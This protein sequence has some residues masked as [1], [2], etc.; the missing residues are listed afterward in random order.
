MGTPHIPLAPKLGSLQA[1]TSH[2]CV[3]AEPGASED[4]GEVVSGVVHVTHPI[5]GK[6]FV[7]DSTS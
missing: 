6:L 2:L 4:T 5:G 3:S 7:K 1:G